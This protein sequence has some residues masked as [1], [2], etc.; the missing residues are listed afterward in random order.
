MEA[1]AG[2][3]RACAGCEEGGDEDDD[4]GVVESFC[5]SYC[6]EG[7]EVVYAECAFYGEQWNES[8]V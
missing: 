7:G 6:G 3:E 8:V 1:G 4:L 2:A 5:L